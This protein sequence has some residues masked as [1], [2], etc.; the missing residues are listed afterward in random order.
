MRKNRLIRLAPVWLCLLLL[1]AAPALAANKSMSL[2]NAKI[3]FP[4]G[5][6]VYTGEAQTPRITVTL[7]GEE[8]QEGRDYTA[9]YSR[10]TDAGEASVRIDAAGDYRGAAKRTFTIKKAENVLTAENILVPASAVDREFPLAC[11]L[12]EDAK[13]SVQSSRKSVTVRKGVVRIKAGFTGVAELTV[14]APASRNYLRVREKLYVVAYET[15]EIL[16]AYSRTSRKAHLSWTACRGSAGTEIQIS[17]DGTFGDAE[18]R[19]IEGAKTLACD[20]DRQPGS[21]CHVRLRSVYRS[22]S[23]EFASK[24]TEPV[25]LETPLAVCLSGSDYQSARHQDPT[26]ITPDMLARIEKAHYYPDLLILCG[27]YVD[28]GA[29]YGGEAEEFIESI[30]EDAEMFFPGFTPARNQL[31]V[32]GNHDKDEGEFAEDGPHEYESFIVY[33]LNTGTSNPWQQGPK[34]PESHDAVRRAAE[35]LADW[36]DGLIEAGETRPVLVATHVPLH[37]SRWTA[38][39]GDNIWAGELFDALNARGDRLDLVFL[40]GHNHGGHGDSSIGGSCILRQPGEDL[41]VP[42]PQDG[43]TAGTKR[44]R[45]ETLTFSYMNAGYIGYTAENK[46]ERRQSFG[47]LQL[48]PDRMEFGRYGLEGPVNVSG[49]GVKTYKPLPDDYLSGQADTVTLPRKSVSGGLDRPAGETL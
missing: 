7:N 36:L 33:V 8:L 13:L 24:W 38:E 28:G 44:Y 23:A 22:K 39:G 9:T 12:T 47:M 30:T 15:P 20:L 14:T 21:V 1:A 43:E 48:Y 11:S 34:W 6:P 19:L 16:E 31:V 32:Q 29:D 37:F 26:T 35:D 18:S 41:L 10:N 4:D 49:A 27:D 25:L 5:S 40:F 3:R 2:K 46:A 42:D 17:E 45:R